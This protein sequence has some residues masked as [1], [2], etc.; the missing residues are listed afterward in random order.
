MEETGSERYRRERAAH[1]WEVPARYNIAADV[2]DARPPTRSRW[3]TRIPTARCGRCT[4]ASSRSLANHAAN[5]LAGLGVRARRPRRGRAAAD[6]G[7]GRHLLRH[8]EARRDP[9]LDVGA[10]RR[11]GD[12][13]PAERL[14]A[15]GARHRRGERAALRG[16]GRAHRARARSRRPR[17]RER[18]VRHRR[19]GRGRPGAALLHL[20][21]DRPREGHRARPP[22]PART[23]R[24]RA[25]ATKSARASA[26]TAWASGPGRPA[27]ARCSDRGASARSSSC[28]S[29]AAASTRTG[30]ST[31]SPGTTR[32]TCSP[33]RRRSAR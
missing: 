32:A 3:C 16:R 19:H 33:R 27:S 1:T 12:R 6:A 25:T 21:H 13:A 4:G 14:R 9:A 22:L 10:L 24:V 18:H 11:R 20:G 17:A 5:L 31:S 29:A 28:S 7:D 15:A 23:Q 26:S 8:L 2:C 30:S